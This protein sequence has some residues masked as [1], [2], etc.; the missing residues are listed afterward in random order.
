MDREVMEYD[1]VIVGGGPAGLSA[2]IRLKQL[3][4]ENNSE[5]SVSVL[6]KG[7]EIGAHI[8]SGAVIDP[9]ALY[10][11]FP[12][13]KDRGAPLTT[14]VSENHHWILREKSKTEF[15][16]FLMPPL[17]NNKGAYTL[18]LG[19]FCRWLAEQAE[20]LGVEVYPGFAGAEV[21]YD[22]SGGVK[23]V[24]MGDMGVAKDGSHKDGYMRGLALLAKYTLFAEGV[25]GSLSKSLIEKY[26]LDKGCEPQT[27]GLGLKE[28]W[29]V[30]EENHTPGKVI[31]TQGW[32][33]DNETVGGG[34]IY[35]QENN[36]VAI[37]FV[38][39]LDYVNPYLSPFHEFQRYKNH[40][41]I[42]PILEGGRR[43]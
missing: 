20:A 34:F 11:L 23:G 4:V 26:A 33:L 32:P 15:P 16:H 6:E 28:L 10:E 7:A 29:D 38:V 9:K 36:Q 1:V 17:M 31:H 41:A 40:P 39:A 22:D 2:A 25:R 27:Y 3:A 13:Y 12:D 30:P 35:F 43:V 14:P 37:G 8:L 21:L 18:S 5:I 24:A 42:R 19:N